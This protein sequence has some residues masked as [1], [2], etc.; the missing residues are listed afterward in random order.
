[1]ST[2]R[3]VEL[4]AYAVTIDPRAAQRQLD[5]V[6]GA[7]TDLLAGHSF[8]AVILGDFGRAV[9]ALGGPHEMG[10]SP[11]LA[12]VRDYVHA[13][14]LARVPDGL[15]AHR[16][17]PRAVD[18]DLIGFLMCEAAMTSGQIALAELIASDV[19]ASGGAPTP[20]RTWTRLVRSR[21]LCFLG[22]LDEARAECDQVL[23]TST[24][25][26][27]THR[28]ARGV[29]GFIDGHMGRRTAL[30]RWC[31]QL[32]VD[33]PE[34]STYADSVVFLLAALAQSAAGN[35][36]AA[37]DVLVFGAGGLD[38]PLLPL[39][40]QAYGYDVLVEAALANAQVPEAGAFLAA[41][42]AL[43]IAAH[44]MAAAAR[45]RARARLALVRTEHA[46]SVAAAET[47]AE[48]AAE[49]GG[50]LYVIRADI[51][52]AVAEAALGDGPSGHRQLDEIARTA[53]RSSSSQVVDW[54]VHELR[55][56]GR[57]IRGFPGIG[58]DTLNA[59][60]QVIARLAA[61]GRR[62]REIAEAMHLSEKTVESHVARIL[63]ALGAT[64]RVGIGRELGGATV[65]PAFGHDLT[66]RQR[67]V[68][69]LVADGCSNGE[70][71]RLLGISEK[72][73][74]K[75]VASLFERLGVRS[76]A[77]IAARVRGAVV[78]T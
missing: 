49:V 18:A 27:V 13:I 72:T 38:M 39:V 10:E 74:E 30:G 17:D 37:A 41:F 60:Q 78:P 33:I 46:E 59:Q 7:P 26:P 53:A 44:S 50:E 64:N 42:D 1:M 76:R 75:H 57:G 63:L 55:A 68:A 3:I 15:G 51:L 23:A 5:C 67:E 16:V 58:W 71:A 32:R 73:V 4:M 47:S 52:R 6:E 9:T 54:A 62:N 24:D 11:L 77:A 70:T 65:D 29:G 31:E 69:V 2:A 8:L 61:Q 28:V 12:A 21:S 19:L 48:L 40:L 20:M 36:T 25:L 22:R 56:V 66:A 35:P 34:P 43:P 45:E 14:C